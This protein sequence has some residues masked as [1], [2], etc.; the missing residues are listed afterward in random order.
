MELLTFASSNDATARKRNRQRVKMQRSVRIVSR[1]MVRP[2][3][4]AGELPE[5]ETTHHLTPLDLRMI[6]VDYVQ[7]GIVLPKPPTGGEHFVEHLES[8]FSRALA[9]FYPLAGRLAVAATA[10]RISVSLLCNGEGAEFVHAVAHGVAVAD[11]A[12]SL[13]VPRVVW[14]F[15]PLNGVLGADAA[16]DSFPLL[17]AQVTELDDG[18]FVAV[19]LNHAVADGFTFWN[20]FNTWSEIT[21]H[22]EALATPA[23][24]FDRWFVETSPIPIPLPFAKLDDMIRRPVYTPVE[25]CFLHFSP[26]SVSSLK[27]T[28]NAEMS[29]V[30]T[31]SS[32][33]AVLAHA[34]RGVCRARRIAP[35]AETMYGLAVGW[36]GRV[37]EASQ[38]YMGNAASPAAAR[39][40]AGEVFDK[41][42]GWL[43]WQLNRAVACADEASVRD[44]L[45]AWPENPVFVYADNLQ[46]RAGGGMAISSSPRFDVY[47]NDFGWGK[48]VAVRSGAGNKIDGKMTVYEGRGG[49]GAMALEVCLSPETLA[50]LVA[51][52]E[53]MAAHKVKKLCVYAFPAV[54]ALYGLIPRDQRRR[55]MGNNDD[56]VAV[57]AIDRVHI[58]SRRVVRPSPPPPRDAGA[59]EVIHLTPWDLRLMSIDYIQKG[60]LL[61]KPPLSGER[62]ADALAASFSRALAVFHPFAGRLVS[63]ERDGEVTVTLRC[64]GE[65]AEFVHAAAPGV[66]VSDIV[67]SLYTPPEVWC[68]YPFKLVLGA[69]ATAAGDDSPALPVLAVQVTELADGVFVG[70]SMN[71]SVGD[72]T[73]FWHFM[74][75][76]SEINRRGGDGVDE[77]TT[78]APVLRR[79]FVETSP[80]PIPMPIGKLQNVI[81]RFERPDVM[82]CFFTFSAASAKKLK[83]RANAENAGT[84]MATATISS[85]QAVLAHLWRAVSRARRLSLSQATFY[86]VLIGC[87]G[88]VNGIPAGYVGN[89]VA[90][91]KAEATAG[92]IEEKGIG[93]TAWL[94]NRAVASFDEADMREW[95]ERWVREPEFTYMSSLQSTAGVA[96]ITGSSPRFDVFGNDFGWGRPVAV[97]SGSGNKMDGKATVFEGPEGGGSMSLEV[98]IAPD[99][100]ARLVTD[101]DFMDAVTVPSR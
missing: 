23:P 97:R 99:A 54:E 24:V 39:A 84:D 37:K 7:K 32:L 8:S 72:G 26:E 9:R 11:I 88:R 3:A 79:W 73:T 78:P 27:A 68:F 44:M 38:H 75:T 100:L 22:G 34:W 86:T 42:I 81:R 20:F 41:G 82:E 66:S 56:N 28:A 25:E 95:L 2:A 63:D 64:S 17:A 48:P 83:A 43:A 91:G 67:S 98:C 18:V 19:S 101:E 62:L 74:N 87:R 40:S 47:G 6:T 13:L 49:S 65:G 55:D 16:V 29:G 50:R 21:R 10:S 52:E 80:V 14:S 69:D 85:L 35:D 94:L 1:R 36:Q 70:M 5:H 53:F 51:D 4:H 58:L 61:P 31:I 15:F 57:A 89:A 12:Y 92:E 30:A 33:Q 90:F 76:W 60:V 93:W 59:D 45:A 77:N 46:R 71:H 96:L